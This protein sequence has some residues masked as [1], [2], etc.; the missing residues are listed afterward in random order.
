SAIS[1][2]PG[3]E[4]CFSS[5][6]Q[7]RGLPAFSCVETWPTSCETSASI[8]AR[9][10]S[11]SAT[12]LFDSLSGRDLFASLA[13]GLELALKPLFD[14]FVESVH[15]VTPSGESISARTRPRR[16]DFL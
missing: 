6:T 2:C 3:I 12:D 13:A 1:N 10:E 4:V 8:S 7:M 11:L 14:P 9:D 15:E 5:R 16:K